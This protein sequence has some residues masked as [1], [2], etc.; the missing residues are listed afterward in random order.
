[1]FKYVWFK[2]LVNS[3]SFKSFL[4]LELT[5]SRIALRSLNKFKVLHWRI[6]QWNPKSRPS[7]SFKISKLQFYEHKFPARFGLHSIADLFLKSNIIFIIWI[8][9]HRFNAVDST[10]VVRSITDFFYL[11]FALP[12]K[13]K[14]TN[15]K[16]YL[17]RRNWRQKMTIQHSSDIFTYKIINNK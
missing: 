11:I 9:T 3:N 14:K 1:M 12:T 2:L 10:S 7:F 4:K 15:N 13:R 8:I 5:N 17:L 16:L 6:I